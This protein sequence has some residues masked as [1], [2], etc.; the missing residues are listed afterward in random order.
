MAIACLAMAMGETPRIDCYRKV[1][2][3]D[4]GPRPTLRQPVTLFAVA[5]AGAMNSCESPLK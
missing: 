1:M 3:V 2:E 5:R 4:G